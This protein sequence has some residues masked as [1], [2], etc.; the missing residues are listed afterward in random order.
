MKTLSFFSAITFLTISSVN[1]VLT[2]QQMTAV[3]TFCKEEESTMMVEYPYKP[4]C[5]SF[6][7]K[8][9]GNVKDVGGNVSATFNLYYKSRKAAQNLLDALGV[10]SQYKLV[11]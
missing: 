2:P 9:W 8:P 7:A 10:S 11:Q 3:E 4:F 6:L 5:E 1:A